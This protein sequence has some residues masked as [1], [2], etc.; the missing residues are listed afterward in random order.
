MLNYNLHQQQQHYHHHHHFELEAPSIS[1][2]DVGYLYE[3]STRLLFVTIEWVQSLDAFQKLAKKDQYNLL[4]NKWHSL[5]VLG[6][7]QSLS[8]IHI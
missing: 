3:I 8:L 6:M 7:A 1:T 5:F 4:L 2:T